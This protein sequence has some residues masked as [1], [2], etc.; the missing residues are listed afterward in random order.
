MA[1]INTET[2]E[3]ANSSSLKFWEGLQDDLNNE[4]F[5]ADKIKEFRG[6]PAKRLAIAFDNLPLPGAF[7]EAIIALRAIIR[8]KRKTEI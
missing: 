8:L 7:Q 6:E 2:D 4:V 3:Q 1:W 5:W